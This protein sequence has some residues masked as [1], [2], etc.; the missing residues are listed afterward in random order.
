MAS[1]ANIDLLPSLLR[2]MVGHGMVL[3]SIGMAC[4]S[5][6]CGYCGV[7]QQLTATAAASVIV[8]DRLALRS[9]RV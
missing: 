1:V 7:F 2:R 4:R 5:G 6:P 9:D 3:L 8:R